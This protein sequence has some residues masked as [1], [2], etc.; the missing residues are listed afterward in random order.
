MEAAKVIAVVWKLNNPSSRDESSKGE[1]SS[2]GSC[3]TE[4]AGTEA[5]KMRAA[6]WKLHNRN[7]RDGSSKDENSRMEA[8]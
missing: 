8:T 3:I 2:T 5:A 1:S 7:S 6:V 4:A